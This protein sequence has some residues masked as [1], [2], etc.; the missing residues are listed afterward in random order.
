MQSL[1]CLVNV[2]LSIF[3]AVNLSY[4]FETYMMM[5]WQI[6]VI[7]ILGVQ[8][9]MA[10]LVWGISSMTFSRTFLH[11]LVS[12]IYQCASNVKVVVLHDYL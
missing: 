7:C 8:M 9:K 12:Y 11:H 2:E 3:S 10:A 4:N 6:E 1:F 5:F